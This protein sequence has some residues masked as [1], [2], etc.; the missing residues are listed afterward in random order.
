MADIAGLSN[1]EWM[2]EQIIDDGPPL[3]VSDPHSD[4]EPDGGGAAVPETV[5]ESNEDVDPRLSPA[6][7]LD[8]A[9]THQAP[10]RTPDVNAGA[11]R[12]LWW[13]GSGVGL[14]AVLIVLAFLVL[15][16]GPAPTTPPQH[17]PAATPAVVA[18]PTTPDLPAPPQDQA[19][20]FDPTTDSCPG[21]PTSPL[22]LTDTATDSAWVCSRGPQE[23]QLDGQ[24]LRVKFLC[25]RSR[26]D[27]RCS[28]MLNSLAVTPG[29]V[30]KTTGGKDEWLQHRCATRM[31]FNFYNGDQLAADP[32]FLDTNCVHGPVPAT[33]PGK[34]LASRV[35]VMILHTERPPAGPRPSTTDAG[36]GGDSVVA[37]PGLVDSLLGS[38]DPAA[39][40]PGTD[41]ALAGAGT[42]GT[43][44]V[45]AT[46]AIS[47]LQFFGHSPN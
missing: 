4:V 21:G 13:L 5:V 26:P 2:L 41:P 19:I 38:A 8:S 42:G 32:F 36:P 40:P 16:G 1:R 12:T 46:F 27:A 47:Q 29:W 28:Y 14:V 44:P 15:G 33:L 34:I 20:P 37:P 31:Q 10:A 23:S 24:I 43:D 35:D 6:Q 39:P 22:A 17:T 25:D 9:E 18:V 11:K 7:D 3:I 30:A 45:D